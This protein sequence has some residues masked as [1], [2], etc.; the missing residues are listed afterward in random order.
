MEALILEITTRGLHRYFP[1]E[2]E[3]TTIGRALDNDIILSDPTV[4]P[5]HLQLVRQEDGSIEVVNLTEV[6]PT[7]IGRQP[8]DRSNVGELPVSMEIGR[9]HA[10]LLPRNLAVPATRPI[11]GLD[12][13]HL[14][15][16]P[17][18]AV[19]LV[20][21]C[22]LAGGLE[23]YFSAYTDYKWTDMAKF[24]LRE[25]VLSIGI[26]IMSL[27]VLERLLVNRW[28]LKQLVTAVCL[29][30][31]AYVLL[32]QLTDG[33]VYLFSASWPSTL[34]QFGWNLL[35]IPCAVALYLIHI[36][37]LKT[38]RSIALAILIASPIAIP[39]L[40]QSPAFLSLLNDFSLAAPYQNSLSPLNWHLAETVSIDTF[41]EQA[42]ELD[43]GEFAD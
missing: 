34:F 21:A 37:H 7:R 33:M 16:H 40:L 27:A 9:I 15:G 6:N 13:R 30:Y 28:E 3:T 17:L 43:P 11:A 18:W 38:S 23:F 29:V 32:I 36:S 24:V 35:L 31:L 4:A 2:S 41:I 22:L 19:L 1:I 12:S 14:F 10:R 25:T 26:L 20:M 5:H 42:Q 8:V 39:T